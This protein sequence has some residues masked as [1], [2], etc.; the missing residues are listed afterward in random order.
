MRYQVAPTRNPKPKPHTPQDPEPMVMSN[1]DA[2]REEVKKIRAAKKNRKGSQLRRSTSKEYE[3]EARNLVKRLSKLEEEHSLPPLHRATSAFDENRREAQKQILE[4]RISRLTEKRDIDQPSTDI[5]QILL[6]R[7]QSN[8]NL[9]RSR[10]K[11]SFF[12]EPFITQDEEL[13]ISELISA[14]RT[15]K[16]HKISS[17]EKDK[18]LKQFEQKL[19]KKRSSET[20]VLFGKRQNMDPESDEE[21]LLEDTH[22]AKRASLLEQEA[23][24]KNDAR[25]LWLVSLR[26][27]KTMQQKFSDKQIGPDGI[28]PQERKKVSIMKTTSVQHVSGN[29]VGGSLSGGYPMQFQERKKVPATKAASM[30]QLLDKQSGGNTMQKR[31]TIAKTTSVQQKYIDRQN[32]AKSSSLPKATQQTA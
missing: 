18:H 10:K 21:S 29:R 2:D 6:E 25:T 22:F 13:Y 16:L 19:A 7:K 9:A 3:M 1:F 28:N 26:D 32:S 15:S 17:G 14:R 12:E 23:K 20:E 24:A 31:V 4:R 30:Q 8:Q 27:R 5:Q 11:Q